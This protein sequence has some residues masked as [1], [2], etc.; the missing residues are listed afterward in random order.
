MVT[1]GFVLSIRLTV[2]IASQVFP[3]RS[4]KVKVNVP[5]V[6]KICHVAFIP[7]MSS[8][9]H[10]RIVHTFVFVLVPDHGV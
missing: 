4:S 6:V 3:A 9:N 5:L 1:T 7:V 8:L 2:A 10:V